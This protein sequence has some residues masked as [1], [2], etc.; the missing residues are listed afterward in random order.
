MFVRIKENAEALTEA[1]GASIPAETTDRP[2]VIAQLL[3]PLS[4]G[5][6]TTAPRLLSGSMIATMRG[7]M[8]V[9]SLRIGDKVFTRDNGIQE[10]RWI[11]HQTV[12]TSA[13]AGNPDLRPVL[14]RKGALGKDAP[15]RDILVSAQHRMLVTS[16][17]AL[18]LFDER[19]VLIAAAD[20]T[21]LA[22]VERI[23]E[24]AMTYVH[25]VFDHHEVV[26]AD[27][28]WTESFQPSDR[29]LRSLGQAQRAE[30]VSVFPELAE[31]NTEAAY[32][33]A[34]K[35]LSRQEASAIVG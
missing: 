13:L 14:I 1:C 9:E 15:Q 4:G 34:R 26:L 19:E 17:I 30:I 35:A 23:E 12:D 16:D 11:G 24:T 2:D 7:E 33:T 5:E 10:I 8:P 21:A 6:E 3:R 27:G 32:P 29:S 20:L 25:I 18:M 31:G 22:G 28:T